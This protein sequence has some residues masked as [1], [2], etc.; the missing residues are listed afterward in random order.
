MPRNVAA[1]AK[2]KAQN[3]DP[4]THGDDVDK[5]RDIIFG[6]QMRE[7][8]GRFEQMEKSLGETIDRLSKT[9]ES[10]FEK[11]ER[12]VEARLQQITERL[13]ADR[14]DRKTEHGA[15]R[16]QLRDLE[17]LLKEQITEA[18]GRLAAEVDAIYGAIEEH[19]QALGRLIEKSQ[20]DFTK[21]IA[22]E[23]ARLE[24]HKIASKD[25]A[26]LFTELARSLKQ[27]GK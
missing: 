27:D 12:S 16:S 26:Q 7:Y 2:Q 9:F 3:N 22:A 17:K 5:I 21:T 18:D 19:Q 8:A 13:A 1:Q 24:R 4:G 20:A 6:G 25:L 10:R 14:E 15:A 23:T 11:L